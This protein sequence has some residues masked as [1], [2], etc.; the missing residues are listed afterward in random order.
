MTNKT[1]VSKDNVKYT[2]QKR[3]LHSVRATALLSS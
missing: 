2:R 1:L 3:A